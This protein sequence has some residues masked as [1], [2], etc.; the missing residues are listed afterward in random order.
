V[1]YDI[2]NGDQTNRFVLGKT[3]ANSLAILG[4]NPS[5]A[6]QCKSDRTINRIEKLIQA[7]NFNGFLM[8]NLYPFRTPYPKDLSKDNDN[9]LIE[10]NTKAIREQLQKS[11][12]YLVWAAWGDDFDIRGYLK[13]CLDKILRETKDLNL[14]WN[15][16][17]SF[18]KAQN[19]RHPL[20]E[21]PHIITEQSQLTKFDIK[22]YWLRKN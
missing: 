10:R 9:T 11:K 1:K 19:P 2:Y 16:C 18:T 20:S 14:E 8:F 3:G 15:R 6:N 12:V 21:R 17:E 7:W 22:E 13:D 4:I 5:T